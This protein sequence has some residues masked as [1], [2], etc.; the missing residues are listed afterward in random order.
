MS[1]S[2]L[3]IGHAGRHAAQHDGVLRVGAVCLDLLGRPAGEKRRGGTDEGITVEDGWGRRER[4]KLA[5]GALSGG[6]VE[7]KGTPL[8][9]PSTICNVRAHTRNTKQSQPG[10]SPR[11]HSIYIASGT[12]HNPSTPGLD[13]VTGHDDRGRDT[14][15]LNRRLHWEF[16]M[17]VVLLVN[18]SA[19]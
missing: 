2:Q 6:C 3:A 12:P 16:D 19:N 7:R 18:L 15:D 1:R 11:A 10:A 14:E 5:A 9:A 8:H 17:A 13:R 4:R